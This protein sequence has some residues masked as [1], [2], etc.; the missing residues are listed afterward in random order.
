MA[1]SE[2][3][4]CR[5]STG[6]D[7][8]CFKQAYHHAQS[9]LDKLEDP[10][11]SLWDKG[12]SEMSALFWRSRLNLPARLMSLACEGQ[13]QFEFHQSNVKRFSERS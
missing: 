8:S 9:K 13:R 11:Q 1:F 6:T 5:P 4:C 3:Y 10:G 7:V 2:R 12:V